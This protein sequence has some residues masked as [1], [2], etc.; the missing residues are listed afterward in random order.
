MDSN[1]KPQAADSAKLNRQSR[2]TQP[3]RL[4]QATAALVDRLLASRLAASH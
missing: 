2:R 3:V 1:Q 4:P